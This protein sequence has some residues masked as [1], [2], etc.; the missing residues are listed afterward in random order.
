MKR[1]LETQPTKEE[2]N[3][4]KK[5]VIET[6]TEEIEVDE[7]PRKKKKSKMEALMECVPDILK[8]MGK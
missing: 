6:V 8:S 2:L 3:S 5:I 7:E 1:K 4:G